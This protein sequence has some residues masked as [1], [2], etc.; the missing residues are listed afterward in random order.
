MNT[1]K[2]IGIAVFVVVFLLL[3]V[4]VLL[5]SKRHL[6]RSIMIDAPASLVFG[7][8]NNFRNWQNWSPWMDIDPDASVTYEG[9]EEGLGSTMIW[10]SENPQVGKGSQRIVVSNPHRRIVTR[11]TFE[12]WDGEAT[13]SWQLEHTQQAANK[14]HITWT[15]DSDNR[16]NLLYKYMDIMI[17]AK[18]GNQYARGLQKLKKHV[19]GIHHQQVR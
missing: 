9:P 17:Y 11:L 1:F 19:E 8:I 18:L 3:A 2:N 5:P 16:G 4:G 10:T 14:T 6:E 13:A 15:N 12:G 7:Q